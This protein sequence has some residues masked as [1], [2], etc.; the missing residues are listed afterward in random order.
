MLFKKMIK[1][2]AWLFLGFFIIGLFIFIN[3]PAIV[4]SQ[5]EKRLPQFLNPAEVEFDI[6]KLG[7]FNT[8]VSKIRICKG[9]S[10]DSINIDYDMTNLSSTHLRKVTVSGLSIHASLDE[11]NHIS[12]PGLAF[13]ETSKQDKGQSELPALS[14]LPEKIVLQN[15]KIVLQAGSDEFLIPLD[16]LSTIQSKQGKIVVQ[17]MMYPFG[18]KINT[19]LT[20]DMNK[21]IESLKI[22]GN[23]FDLE[24]INPLIAEKLNGIQLKG[25]FDF[26]LESDAPDKEWKIY[27]SQIGLANS[28]E[29]AIKDI[30]ATLLMD[31]HKI[32]VDGT[33]NIF[34][35]MVPEIGM[36]YG[37]TLDLE[38]DYHFDA[39]LQ[40]IKTDN[41]K[42][43]LDSN[44]VNIINPEFMA[45]FNG[46]PQNSR[47]KI[48]LKLKEGRIQSPGF[49][50]LASDIDIAIPVQY[51]D[52]GNKISGKYSIPKILYNNQHA[53][54][55]KGEITQLS[56]K[57]FQVNGDMIF[58]TLPNIKTRFKSVLG[59]EKQVYAS[60]TFKTNDFKLSD[61]DI[62]KLIP[63][64]QQGAKIDVTA[65]AEGNAGYLNHQIKSAMRIQ[66]RDGNIAAPDMKLTAKGI[67]TI[68]KFNDLLELES[69]PGQMLTIES[70]E[71]D[72]I[73]L[74]NAKVRFSIEQG[75]SLL[76][77]NMRFA[78]CNGLVS[79]ES[80]RF[81]QENNAYFLTLYCDRLEMTQLLK[82]M[83]LFNAQG[84]GT[85]N[86]RIPVLYS[87]G[88]ISFDNGFLFSTPGSGGKVVIENTDKITAGIP[89]DNPQFGQLDLARE[90]LKDFDYQWAKL[91]FNTFE[92]TLDVK[93]EIDGKPSN[94]L[95]FEYRKEFGGF[96]RV[97]A[98]SPGSVFEGIKL[99]V[100]LK[101]PFNEVMKFGNKIK[102]ILN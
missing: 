9:I 10:I 2:S 89:M 27:V 98:S 14:F 66:V 100:N 64:K 44:S 84:N 42:I 24:H 16:I 83:G 13:P 72:K 57:E 69:E 81:P 82:Q 12:I 102:S 51:P 17:A 20:Y 30:T 101:L 80:I 87:D 33:F 4:E 22:E 21:G 86:G 29:T 52:T 5:I 23:S 37:V 38:N 88:N 39:K 8:F 92:N 76:V 18:E 19:L 43:I 50:T 73:Q 41:Y 47:G 62:E 6:Q 55:T 32:K 35:P 59:F 78:W 90:A 15:S 79:T 93:L 3:L 91:I 74:S 58:K 40:N 60:V 61:K 45:E 70:I 53:F 85:L 96:G 49:T 1:I 34:H 65:F 56:L 11:N 31:K 54:S 63:Q 68:I 36:K 7:F 67:N 95:P 71:V 25:P 48:L 75:K 46:T 97:D 26:D 94:T 77:E 28:F 99:D